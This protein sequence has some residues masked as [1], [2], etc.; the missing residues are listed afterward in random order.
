MKNISKM[1]T[2]T[3]TAHRPP[4]S[5]SIPVYL[6]F[7][8]TSL[9]PISL[10]L[11]LVLLLIVDTSLYPFSTVISYRSFTKHIQSGLR[12]P[13]LL[14]QGHD[15]SILKVSFPNTETIIKHKLD[16]LYSDNTSQ[17]IPNFCP[18]PLTNGQFPESFLQTFR[19]PHQF[20]KHEEILKEMFSVKLWLT[21]GINPDTD[22]D[23]LVRRTRMASRSLG[24]YCS[25]RNRKYFY[26]DHAPEGGC[27]GERGPFPPI[28]KI[29]WCAPPTDPLHILSID[30]GIVE[31]YIANNYGS[32]Y[33]HT[34]KLI[35]AANHDFTAVDGNVTVTEFDELASIA[36]AIYVIDAGHFPNEVLHSLLYL[37]YALPTR[38]PLLWPTGRMASIMYENLKEENLLN[39][40]RKRIFVP[41]DYKDNSK[42]YFRAKRLYFIRSNQPWNHAP[43]ISW[44]GQ[45]FVQQQIYF[46]VLERRTK[47]LK[48]TDA[49]RKLN[50]VVLQRS[51]GVRILL[52]HDELM[53][54]LQK[55]I[56]DANIQAFVPGPEAGH[57]LWDTAERIYSSCFLIGPHGANIPNEVFLVPGCWVIE[58]GYV[59]KKLPLPADFYCFARNLD[60]NYWLSIGQG[61]YYGTI[62][63]DLDDIGEI[64]QAYKR[65][66]LGRVN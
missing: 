20:L 15:L 7:F 34:D 13:S 46:P 5:F 29:R 63:A 31:S 18:Y 43:V 45:R 64:V 58:I 55:W 47:H 16:I 12:E 44:Y 39:P 50:I 52:N 35:V 11:I 32:F 30:C 40:K 26:A 60:L 59:D 57:P 33:I 38:I 41:S 37:D 22:N 61:S 8:L 14:V 9:S 56:P 42:V 4:V 54:R 6:Q 21:A 36:G 17:Y 28:Y 23:M 49:S 24:T 62:T 10:L 48:I 66:V 2:S 19:G 25:K 27:P 1:F 65:E 53:D 3:S 51:T